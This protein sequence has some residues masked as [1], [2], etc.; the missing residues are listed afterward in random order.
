MVMS[1]ETIKENC[2]CGASVE[3][4]TDSSLAAQRFIADWR[5]QHRHEG[6]E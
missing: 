3:I 5:K 1:K 4:Y 2:S 6:K